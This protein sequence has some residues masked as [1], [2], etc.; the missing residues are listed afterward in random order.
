MN[1]GRLKEI[2]KIIKK[3]NLINDRSPKTVRTT[4]EELGPTFI[5]IG[6]ILSTR[7]DLFDEEYIVELSKLRSNVKEIDFKDIQNILFEAYGNYTSIFSYVEE[8]PIGSA[9]IAQVHKAKLVDGQDV[10]LKIKRPGV[11]QE[12]VEDFELLKEA[13]NVLHLNTLVKVIDMDLLIDELYKSTLEELDFNLEIKNIIEFSNNNSNISTICA[14]FVIDALSKENILVMEYI[15][16]IY[17]NEV[18]KLQEEG[19]KPKTIAKELCSNY[20][21]Q[22]IEDGLFHAD[23]HSDNILVRN[24]SIVFIDWGMVGRLSSK[25]KELLDKCIEYIVL[26]D[27]DSVADVLVNMSRVNGELDKNK[28]VEGISSIISKYANLGLENI[29]FR[30]FTIEA[31]NLLRDNNL[32]LNYDITMLLRGICIIESVIKKLDSSISLMSVFEDRI[33]VK[34]GLN[35]NY[36]EI[37]KK[38]V[39]TTN[40]IADIPVE[41]DS[42]IKK[43]N[44][45]DF[46]FKFELSDSRN[47][48]DKLENLVHEVILGFID[49]CLIV[50]FSIIEMPDIKLLFLIAIIFISGLLGVKMI[51]DLVHHGY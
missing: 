32:V 45:K 1:K 20:I 3:N 22:A 27:Y 29:Y 51:L 26:E 47:H 35:K 36:K 39:K 17:V 15:D 33:I 30:E 10:V 46:K 40:S 8:R 44:D 48:V 21:K 28:L 14:P 34:R 24:D 19:Y 31:L 2:I 42:F 43:V 5:K 25:N 4:L 23:P 9:S 49:G 11:D 37:G 41:L 7:V 13:I 16:G 50:G 18:E 6:Q 38:I 12:I